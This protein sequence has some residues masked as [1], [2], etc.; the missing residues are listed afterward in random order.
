MRQR[1]ILRRI[2][3]SGFLGT[4]A[5]LPTAVCSAEPLEVAK[6]ERAEPVDFQQEL[7]PVLRKKC[8]ACHNAS[9]AE[10]DVV[11]E[12]P[13]TIADG[14]ASGPLVEPGN[15]AE[16]MLMTLAAHRDEPI[17][18]P[19][20]NEADAENL[21]AEE[22]AL[23]EL[24]INQGAEGEVKSAVAIEWQPLPA[25]LNPIYA[26]AQSRD[27]RLV[28]AGRG[29]QIWLYDTALQQY[30]GTL[31]DP[32][33]ANA[34][35]ANGRPISHLDLV[36]S[37]A[38]SADGNRIAS[39][40]YR[41]VKLWR[42]LRAQQS[43]DRVADQPIA[44]AEFHGNQIFIIGE[45]R[46]LKRLAGITEDEGEASGLG[47]EADVNTFAVGVGQLAVGA[48]NQLVVTDASGHERA[49]A[50]TSAPIRSIAWVEQSLVVGLESGD[51][52][53]FNFNAET[54]TLA[55]HEVK[56]EAHEATITA[57]SGSVRGFASGDASGEVRWY[58]LD[59]PQPLHKVKHPAAVE[60]LAVVDQRVVSVGGDQP[61]HLWNRA[62]G[63]LVAKLSGDRVLQ[64]KLDQAQLSL[65][66][67]NR[68]VG[69]QKQDLEA[70]QKRVTAEE[71][72]LKKA[73]ETSNKLHEEVT[74][75]EEATQQIANAKQE[76]EA[77]LENA[78]QQQTTAEAT[79]AEAADDESKQKAQSV[80]DTAKQAVN[81][82]AEELKK[83]QAEFEKQQKAT[84]DKQQSLES[85]KR[86]ITAAENTLQSAKQSVA[87][88]E[89]LVK[90]RE[91]EQ[92][93]AKMT[94]EA[95]QKELS[96]R[97]TVTQGVA[98]HAGRVIVVEEGNTEGQA[99]VAFYD[100]E[101]GQLLHSISLEEIDECRSIAAKDG[102]IQI[103]SQ[104]GDLHRI[105]TSDRWELER[106]V[107]SA[108]ESPFADRVTAL[109]FHQQDTMLAV[110]GGEPSR[111]GQL[112]I[113][114]VET[115][116]IEQEIV[117]AHSDTVFG[118]AFS[119]DGKQ[120][121]S[122]G[123]DR[124]M[125]VFDIESGEL[126]K[127]FEGHTHHVLCVG[128]R[129][130]GRVLATGGADKVVKVWNVSDGSQ[131]KTIQGFGKEIVALQFAGS[132]DNFYAAC[133]DQNLYRCDV[134][135]KRD[136]VGRGEDFLYSVSVSAMGDAIAFAGHDSV[137]RIVD[138][139]GKV[140]SELKPK[141]DNDSH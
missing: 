110:G 137:V 120:I 86:S 41:T 2:V 84:T 52:L 115:G 109:A 138:A 66:I 128:W 90:Q 77:K 98:I 111:S 135:G 43:R 21:T 37:L 35:V 45:D 87:S 72:N 71:E 17:M 30:A 78:R 65:E 64:W 76:L 59:Q 7:L 49:R 34:P 24:W 8:L 67:A 32:E 100:Q 91:E 140:V 127:T 83:K 6:L 33:L 73:T 88:I 28:A 124:F 117:D 40:G 55:E 22:L 92:T 80:L 74:K 15:A 97:T 48:G 39:G 31:T 94:L 96:E 79:L 38:M 20:D 42:R 136:S 95:I 58:Q 3:R 89:P 82:A 70:A 12:S 81:A 129:A 1:Y 14:G 57:L 105:A 5:L 132:T 85:A 112:M 108:T 99:T 103:V 23:L 141:L 126:V 44:A 9:D 4:I 75:F 133:G 130:D 36:Q 93:S 18:P 50:E 25:G 11:L 114:D 119:P 134:G 61:A 121:A 116:R 47:L 122:C 62:D 53:R 68:Q 131:L 125:K 16:S 26:V 29:N 19:E 69:N 13:Q 139:D 54:G 51:I 46:K 27:G 118:L 104:R 56:Y 101:S 60:H 106:T 113:V 123:A 63:Q 107:G 102:V 10:G